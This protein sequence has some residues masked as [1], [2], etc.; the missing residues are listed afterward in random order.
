[1]A[2]VE[3]AAPLRWLLRSHVCMSSVV[4]RAL[5]KNGHSI[6]V[7]RYSCLSEALRFHVPFQQISGARNTTQL[8]SFTAMGTEKL[9]LKLL[10]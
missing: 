2:V 7:S 8:P 9:T 3:D 6:P 5:A 4:S 1:M 10:R